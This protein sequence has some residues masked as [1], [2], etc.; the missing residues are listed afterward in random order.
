MAYPK[1]AQE[2]N[3]F[4][5]LISFFFRPQYR[6]SLPPSPFVFG[7]CLMSLLSMLHTHTTHAGGTNGSQFVEKFYAPLLR[8]KIFKALVIAVAVAGTAALAW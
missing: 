2:G 1:T 6:R 3:S 7:L 8:N 5:T 4:K